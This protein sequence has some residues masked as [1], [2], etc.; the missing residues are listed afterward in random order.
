[1]PLPTLLMRFMWL[2][3]GTNDSIEVLK[4]EVPMGLC[5]KRLLEQIETLPTISK[6]NTIDEEEF[7]FGGCQKS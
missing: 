5:L 7:S 2:D 3:I 4:E 1:M 6:L